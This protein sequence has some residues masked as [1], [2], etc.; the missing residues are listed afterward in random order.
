MWCCSIFYAIWT[1]PPTPSAKF[2]KRVSGRHLQK[3]RHLPPLPFSQFRGSK[4]HQVKNTW[5]SSRGS[6]CC[7]LSCLLPWLCLH[8]AFQLSP[9]I[10]SHWCFEINQQ[11]LVIFVSLTFQPQRAVSGLQGL[12]G[13]KAGWSVYCT[14]S[15]NHL[16]DLHLCKHTSKETVP[17]GGKQVYDLTRLKWGNLHWGKATSIAEDSRVSFSHCA[18]ADGWSG[19]SC[20]TLNLSQA[21]GYKKTELNH[22]AVFSAQ[23]RF[24]QEAEWEHL[25]LQLLPGW[26]WWTLSQGLGQCLG[27]RRN[28]ARNEV[29]YGGRK[30]PSDLKYNLETIFDWP[31]SYA[32]QKRGYNLNIFGICNFWDEY[33]PLILKFLLRTLPV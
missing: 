21:K 11:H 25:N 9:L 24:H 22:F 26:L 29:K 5:T 10:S 7:P 6:A 4:W 14:A 33:G 19:L 18:V 27:Q 3:I 20:L 23:T 32:R 2:L 28:S 16:C 12:G 30:G 17:Q 13:G 1:F 15:P 31:S 8:C